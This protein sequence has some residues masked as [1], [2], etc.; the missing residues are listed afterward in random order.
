MRDNV[1]DA[2][3]TGFYYEKYRNDYYC[4]VDAEDDDEEEIEESD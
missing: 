3:W 2:P 1:P 4:T